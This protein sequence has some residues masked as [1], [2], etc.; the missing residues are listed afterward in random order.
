MALLIAHDAQAI[1]VGQIELIA[2][3]AAHIPVLDG[4]LHLGIGGG[5]SLLQFGNRAVG[6]SGIRFLERNEFVAFILI[7]ARQ[8]GIRLLRS[9]GTIG[10]VAHTVLDILVHV[11]VD[12]SHGAVLIELCAPVEAFGCLVGLDIEAVVGALLLQEATV[13]VLDA[14]ARLGQGDGEFAVARVELEHAVL[15]GGVCRLQIAVGLRGIERLG[16]LDRAVHHSAHCIGS[17][18]GELVHGGHFRIVINLLRREGVLGGGHL[19]GIVIVV[20]GNSLQDGRRTEDDRLCVERARGIVGLR[21]VKRIVDGGVALAGQR[22]R[23]LV[24]IRACSQGGLRAVLIGRTVGALRLGC[25]SLPQG[26]GLGGIEGLVVGAGNHEVARP[27]LAAAVGIG[28]T[29]QTEPVA[30]TSSKVEVASHIDGLLQLTIHIDVG[31][32]LLLVPNANHVIIDVRL[33]HHATVTP[34]PLA[35]A[36]SAHIGQEGEL[37]LARTAYL[38]HEEARA[39]ALHGT[40]TLGLGIED[41]AIIVPHEQHL[42]AVTIGQSSTD[43]AV[44]IV[45]VHLVPAGT[46][47]APG[48]GK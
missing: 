9:V 39:T 32:V 18:L 40:E 38:G 12:D 11:Q 17:A 15:L 45:I 46:G 41:G 20:I 23:L 33:G 13:E 5:G 27:A 19:A 4:Q 3:H 42:Q 26:T 29:T 31:L 7:Q 25:H 8:H 30:G 37:I 48:I 34:V 28:I 24:L 10:T 35:L 44:C 6:G 1:A 21:A 14:R 36:I 2:V 47:F 22:H 16:H 43:R